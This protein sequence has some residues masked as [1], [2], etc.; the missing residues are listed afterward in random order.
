MNMPTNQRHQLMVRLPEELSARLKALVPPRQR[1]QFITNLVAGAVQ[2]QEAKLVIVAREVT[3]EEQSNPDLQA[4]LQDWDTT[5]S[6][7]LNGIDDDYGS[8]D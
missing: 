2:E 1:N 6:D 4:E 8:K 5:I 7:G 3:A